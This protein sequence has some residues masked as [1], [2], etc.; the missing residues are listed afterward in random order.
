VPGEHLIDPW[1]APLAYLTQAVE[2]G[3]AARFSAEVTG[4]A[5]EDGAWR[6]DTAAGPVHA[7]WVVNCAGL[8]GDRVERLLLGDASFEIRPRKGQFVVFDKAAARLLGTTVLAVPAER[9][10]GVV[11][12]RTVWGNLLVGPTAEDQESREDASTDAGTLA[13]LIARA[14]EVLPDLASM[15][16]TAAYAGI[17]PA[18]EGKDYRIRL[19]RERR[20]LTL[21][22]IRSTGLT[23]A[24]GLAAR[25]ARLLAAAGE[26]FRPLAA[27]RWP[28]T[29]ALAEHAERDWTK[30]GNGGIVCHCEL[31]TEREILT[32]VS[33]PLPARDLGGLKRRTRATMG[34]CQG[35]YCLGR[36]SRLTE[37]RLAVPIAVG[38]AHG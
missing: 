12:C 2:N 36:L 10:K 38:A 16:V 11:L 22:G 4:G 14:A 9:T 23:A 20:W 35:F 34:R 5:F 17:R 27:P 30:P 7:R 25:A 8:Y 18:S 6:L 26:A 21:G 24:L 31:V 15:P 19:E 37:G 33:G 13:A 32:A 1:S 28:A 3:A 29:P